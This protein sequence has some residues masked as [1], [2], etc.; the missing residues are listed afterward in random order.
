VKP[1]PAPKE[2]LG[3]KADERNRSSPELKRKRGRPRKDNVSPMKC[4]QE[5][6]DSAVV[7]TSLEGNKV[8]PERRYP[9]R[10]PLCLLFSYLCLL[11]FVQ[12][13]SMA[14]IESRGSVIF[15]E[16]T[17]VTFSE[18]A[19]VIVTHVPM[20]KMT[21]FGEKL[22]KWLLKQLH[23]AQPT[24]DRASPYS[25]MGTLI[26]SRAKRSLQRLG[27]SRLRLKETLSAVKTSR[28]K[29]GIF[30]GVG[31]GFKWLFGVATSSDRGRI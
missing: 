11:V 25:R 30:D 31:Q 26:N 3:E 8:Q 4:L 23:Q 7:T 10:Y 6:S 14:K 29:R 9:R 22:E 12:G 16:E 21:V 2:Q 5:E 28:T 1:A 13:V 20:G 17:N 15:K 27:A 24:L 19:W 18:S